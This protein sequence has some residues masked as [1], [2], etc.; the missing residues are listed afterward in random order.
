MKSL[1]TNKATESEMEILRVLWER[2]P[3]TVREVH[4]LLLKNKASGYTTTLKLMQIMLEKGLL[5]RNTTNRTHVYAC[6]VKQVFFQK[7]LVGKI[8]DGMFKGSPAQLIMHALGNHRASRDELIEIKKYLDN[9]VRQ[10]DVKGKAN[11]KK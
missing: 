11:P 5:T 4:E 7:Q 1:K 3:S 6:A 2:G 9:I 10:D 8:I